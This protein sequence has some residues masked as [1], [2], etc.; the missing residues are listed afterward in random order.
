MIPGRA[1]RC[2]VVTLAALA[3]LGVPRTASAAS[4]RR[5]VVLGLDAAD[6]QAI[7]PL[8][9][10]GRL[11][12]LGRLAA[13]GRALTLVATPPLVSPIIWTTIA[14][15]RRPEDHRVLDF[16]VDLPGGGQAPVPSSERKTAAL[17]NV[18][19]DAGRSVGVVGWWATWPAEAVRGTV[20]ADRVAPQLLR[21]DPAIEAGSVSPPARAGEVAGWLVRATDVRREDLAAY[22]PLSVTEYGAAREALRSAGGRLYR[23]PLAHLA[24][25]VASTRSYGRIAEGLVAAGQPDL[26]LVYLETIDSVSHLFARD[27]R[28]GP[29]AIARAYEDADALLGRLA[30][31]V[32]PDTWVLVVSDHGFYGTA[33]GIRE[34]PADLAG[35]ATAWHRPY[36]IAAAAEARELL[37][38][39]PAPSRPRQPGLVTPLDIAPTVLHAAGLPTSRELPGRVVTALLP[40]EAA[41]RP[42]TRVDTLERPRRAAEAVTLAPDPSAR[43]R[44]RAL[45][46]V[47]AATTSLARLN[48]GEILYRRGDLD[49]AERELRAVLETQPTNLSALLWL[50]KAVA[51]QG[52]ARSALDVYAR[53][54]ALPGDSGDALV[55]AVELAA[56]AKLPDEAQRMLAAAGPSGRATAAAAVGRAIAARLGGHAEAAERELRLALSTDPTFLPALERLLDVCV[57]TRRA[58]DAVAPLTAAADRLPRSPRHQALAGMALLASGDGRAAEQRLARAAA[59]APD[60]SSVRE[61]LARAQLTQGHAEAALATLATVTASAEADALRGAAYSTR[62]EWAPAAAAYERALAAGPATPDLLN[63]LGWARVQLGQRPEAVRLLT[64]SLALQP[65]QPDIRKLLAEIQGQGR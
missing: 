55:A 18:F 1:G 58:A 35:P 32:A 2:L 36:G 20:V 31:R 13:C 14:T 26:L 52:R 60:A 57:A 29:R 59:L 43:E 23:D 9:A 6:W 37:E 10:A 64:R 33:A 41:A 30:A 45:G 47:G 48:L 40:E 65:G 19:S 53:A 17:W 49:G 7:D 63:A 38:G 3:A 8:V 15:G 25:I 39:G 5:I 50:A 42:V 12:V 34:D 51:A 62:R 28:R 4:A 54:L 46:Y 44:L 21:S 16:M 22:V 11:P 27:D 61:E 24:A 56:E